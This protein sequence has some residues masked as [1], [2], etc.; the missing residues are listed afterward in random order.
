MDEER[1]NCK[2]MREDKKKERYKFKYEYD[3]MKKMQDLEFDDIK[4][5]KVIN[6]FEPLKYTDFIPRGLII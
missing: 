1:L 5:K 6:R 3:S 4:D 2:L